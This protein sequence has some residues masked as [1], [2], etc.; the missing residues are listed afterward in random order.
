METLSTGLKDIIAFYTPKPDLKNLRLVRKSFYTSTTRELF[1]RVHVTPRQASIK[2]FQAV[3]ASPALSKEVTNAKLTTYLNPSKSFEFYRRDD[4]V[5][6]STLTREYERIFSSINGFPNLRDVVIE[7]SEVCAVIKPTDYFDQTHEEEVEFRSQVLSILFDALN[8]SEEA[9]HFINNFKQL[10]Q[11]I[12][13]LRLKIVTEYEQSTPDNSWSR[14]ELYIFFEELPDTWLQPTQ[15]NLTRL[16]LHCN[17]HWGYIPKCDFLCIHFPSLK[18]LEL[19]N[20][21]FSHDWQVDWICSRTTLEMVILDDCTI[22][23]HT[24]TFGL[25]DC[26]GYWVVPMDEDRS[27]L[28]D[29]QFNPQRWSDIFAEFE[30]RLP[31]IKSF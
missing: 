24:R 4:D 2:K 8:N 1:S 28:S 7:L 14:P 21:S 10:L 23:S 27:F 9:S 11:R 18:K 25:V 3:L 26:E 17:V 20:Y 12:T 19:G 22:A 16:T 5:R 13:E 29:R 31:N 15:Q 6:E 30:A